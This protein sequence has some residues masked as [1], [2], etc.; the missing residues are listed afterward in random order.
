MN[1]ARARSK[2]SC[3][4]LRLDVIRDDDFVDTGLDQQ[5]CALAARHQRPYINSGSV[6]ADTSSSCE[7]HAVGLGVSR[8]LEPL[9][10]VLESCI[11]IEDTGWQ[12]IKTRDQHPPIAHCN[13]PDFGAR[14]FAPGG[15]ISCHL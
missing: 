12:A 13:S 2:L 11:G 1:I 8:E 15:N 10:P 3:H 4:P 6:E 7:C 5:C 14:I 9:I